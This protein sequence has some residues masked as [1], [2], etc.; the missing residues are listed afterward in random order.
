MGV[1][2][3]KS[4]RGFPDHTEMISQKLKLNHEQKWQSSE[5][6]FS[7]VD[8]IKVNNKGKLE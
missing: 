4:F 5:G 8:S 6:T 7:D 3:K 1:E 2:R